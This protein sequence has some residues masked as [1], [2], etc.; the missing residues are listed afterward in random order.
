MHNK[1]SVALFNLEM[2]A[3][4]LANRILQ[5]LGQINGSKSDKHP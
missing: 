2:S 5:S 4:Q 1:K 3:E